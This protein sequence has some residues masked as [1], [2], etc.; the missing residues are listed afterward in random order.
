MVLGKLEPG[1]KEELEESVRAL[2]QAFNDA[3]EENQRKEFDKQ[4]SILITL[5]NSINNLLIV[6]VC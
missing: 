4:K 2:Q 6:R 1:E 3:E 5:S